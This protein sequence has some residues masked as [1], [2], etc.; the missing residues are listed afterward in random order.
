MRKFLLLFSFVLL[1]VCTLAQNTSP[2]TVKDFIMVTNGIMDM[3]QV[4]KDSRTDWDSNPVCLIKVKASG[5]D[6]NLMQKFI[7]VPSGLSIMHKT[8]KNGQVYLYVSSNKNGEIVVKYMG[9]CVFSLPYKLEG[10]KIYE[11]TLGMET[12][13][14]IIR[15]VPTDA[16]IFID[17]QKVGTGYASKAVSIGVEHRW[18]VQSDDFYPKEGVMF[19]KQRE[20]RILDVEL[21]PNFGYITVKTTPSG[22]DVLIDEKLV[23]RTPYQMKRI[24]PGMHVV[25]VRKQGYDSYADMVTIKVGEVNK[26]MDNI[27]LEAEAVQE[28][29]VKEEDVSVHDEIDLNYSYDDFYVKDIAFCNEGNNEVKIDNYGAVLYSVRTRYIKSKITYSCPLYEAGEKDFYIKITKSDGTLLSGSS[30]PAGFT[31]K[32]KVKILYGDNNSVEI[33]GWG[34]ANGGF[35]KPG[36]YTYEIWCDGRLLISRDFSIY[37]DLVGRLSRS[38]WTVKALSFA[39]TDYDSNIIDDYGETMRASTLQYL[40]VSMTYD[41]FEGNAGKTTIYIKIYDNNGNLMTGTSSPEGYTTSVERALVY[42]VDNTMNIG[43]WGNKVVGAYKTG[44]YIYEV[45]VDGERVYSQYVYIK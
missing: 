12:A 24:A 14:L 36:T 43:G 7:F 32:T 22:A 41:C 8:I 4:P 31:T 35:Y 28:I 9:D 20:E 5:Y 27:T 18:K 39:N 13:T 26:V 19:F 10:H 38:E 16:D 11:L 23:G 42:G 30:S 6:E 29:Y 21:E 34:T 15:S 17:N 25:E 37:E 40:T 45:W 3:D 2:L 44:T 1:G 33:I